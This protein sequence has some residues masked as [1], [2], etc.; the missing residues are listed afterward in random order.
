MRARGRAGSP[1][2]WLAARK[3][4]RLSEAGD[5]PTHHGAI[6]LPLA[7]SHSFASP[8]GR[9]ALSLF[10]RGQI[11]AHALEHFRSHPDRFTQR[12]MGMDGLADIDRIATQ[13]DRE[14][15]FAD[16][17]SGMG[18]HDAAAKHAV[19]GLIE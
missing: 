4:F 3:S 6:A 19:V 9:N 15:D 18:P 16:Q 13:L 14:A 17:V 1:C 8:P 11:G 10:H 5:T 12:G 2:S 7:S